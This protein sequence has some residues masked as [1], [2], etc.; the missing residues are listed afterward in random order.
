[1]ALRSQIELM[2]RVDFFRGFGDEHLR[3]IGF[4]SEER[5][6]A[7]GETLYAAGEPLNAA[8]IVAEGNLTGRRGDGA[9]A[10]ERSI[11]P[12]TLLGE[13]ALMLEARAAETVSAATDARLIEIR[14]ASFRRLLEEY[15]AIAAA[16]R[17][18]LARRFVAAAADYR[19]VAERLRDPEA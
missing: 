5:R 14:R 3:L 17:Q 10:A 2:R 13:T 16:L 8:Y 12:A 9:R 6:L 15:P 4:S 19:R 18:R 7:A 11:G 1:M